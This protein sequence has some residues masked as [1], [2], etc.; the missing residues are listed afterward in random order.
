MGGRAQALW[1]R[2]SAPPRRYPPQVNDILGSPTRDARIGADDRDPTGMTQG[3]SRPTSLAVDNPHRRWGALLNPAGSAAGAVW[4]RHET[5]VLV[6]VREN[7]GARATAQSQTVRQRR[8]G[9]ERQAPHGRARQNGTE[10]Q[11]AGRRAE[12]LG[13]IPRAGSTTDW[14]GAPL[15]SGQLNPLV[16]RRRLV[17]H[18][19]HLVTVL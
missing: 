3:N 5:S 17:S 10:K 18:D 16:V 2:G 13:N 14:V 1:P 11:K 9:R 15:R 8:S 7:R 19:N 6:V 12:G 4:S